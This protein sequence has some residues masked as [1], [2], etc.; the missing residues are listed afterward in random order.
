MY[1]PLRVL[2]GTGN[3]G[4]VVRHPSYDNSKLIL[5]DT[6]LPLEVQYLSDIKIAGY[7]KQCIF[8]AQSLI[9]EGDRDQNT[10][11]TVS[12]IFYYTEA[13][14]RATPDIRGHIGTTFI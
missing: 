2:E 8:Q 6:E 5:D 10:V 13:F 7:C 11:A 9:R 1:P 3:N 14:Q 4:D 12:M